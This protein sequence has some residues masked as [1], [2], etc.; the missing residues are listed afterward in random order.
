MPVS[1]LRVFGQWIT[2]HPWTEVTEAEDVN[3]KWENHVNTTTQAYHLYFPVRRVVEHPNDTPWMST[4]IKRLLRQR[5]RLY[6]T[7]NVLYR[8]VRNSVIRR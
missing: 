7:D 2:H 3:T 1:A 6:H 4:R 5:N 8:E